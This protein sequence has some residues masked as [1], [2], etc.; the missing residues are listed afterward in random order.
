M[1]DCN[2]F[3]LKQAA[4]GSQANLATKETTRKQLNLVCHKRKHPCAE[5]TFSVAAKGERS[6]DGKSAVLALEGKV[7]YAPTDT[8][9]AQNVLTVASNDP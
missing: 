5:I 2:V 4:W 6:Q 8:R 3:C 7:A 1:I 9:R